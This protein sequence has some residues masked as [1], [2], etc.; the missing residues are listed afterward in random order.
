MGM[1]RPF[2]VLALFA[3]GASSSSLPA[4]EPV[5]TPDV[6]LVARTI[7]EGVEL[8]RWQMGRPSEI[9]DPSPVAGVS[10]RE[11]FRQSM[12][13]WEKV[14]QLGIELV[15]G[16]ESP[17]LVRA[18]EGQNYGPAEVH[19]V[20][21][22]VLERL[23]EIHDGVGIVGASSMVGT[24]AVPE[25]DPDATPSDV[26]QVVVQS[27]R[28][29]NRMLEREAQPG[30]VYRN[31][32]QAVFYASEILAAVG[33]PS[34]MPSA[35]EYEAGLQPAHVY[36]RLLQVFDRTAAAFDAVGLTMV[37][38]SGGAYE[39]DPSLTPGDV[40]DLTTLLLAELE[41]M[42]AMVPGARTPMLAPHPGRRW[43]SDVYQQAGILTEQTARLM[44]QARANP[45]MV[46]ARR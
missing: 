22:S 20:L 24:A 23:Q 30:D 28:Q 2:A 16:G 15:G 44:A 32:Q 25:I 3:L 26:F 19:L 8:L 12:A 35:P 37:E 46:V 39:I 11:N 9:R 13:L 7:Q 4:Q 38:W 45:S 14:N 41:Y 29:V 10:I 21:T 1:F 17:P 34:P 42:H 5:G 33:D 27:N 43:P 18:P 40:Y 6:H 31:V 36:G